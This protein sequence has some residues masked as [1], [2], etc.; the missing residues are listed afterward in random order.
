V[1]KRS[2]DEVSVKPKASA[3]RLT[4]DLNS[5]HVLQVMNLVGSERGGD[6]TSKRDVLENIFGVLVPSV[7]DRLVEAKPAND[8]GVVEADHPLGTGHM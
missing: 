7:L 5:D 8:L 4:S 3:E 1:L 2:P 6:D